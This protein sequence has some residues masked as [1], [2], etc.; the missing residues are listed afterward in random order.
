[1]AGA[2][3]QPRPAGLSSAPACRCEFGNQI[4]IQGQICEYSTGFAGFEAK[5]SLRRFHCTY[6]RLGIGQR[7]SSSSMRSA[8]MMMTACCCN[9]R[10]ILVKASNKFG[11]TGAAA[12]LAFAAVALG[13]TGA[14]AFAQPP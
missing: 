9:M 13:D 4:I 3:V 12:E 6:T 10:S 8:I 14:A 1:M 2:K 5:M 7:R 11:T